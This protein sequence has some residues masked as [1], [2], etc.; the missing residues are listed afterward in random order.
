M[1]DV[2]MLDVILAESLQIRCRGMIMIMTK[3]NNKIFLLS[4]YQIPTKI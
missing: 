3:N 2:Y 4:S 1:I